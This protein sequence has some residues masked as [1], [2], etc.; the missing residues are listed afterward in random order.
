MSLVLSLWSGAGAVR[1]LVDGL[2]VAY[3]EKE[4]RTF[5]HVTVLTL[6]LTVGAILFALLAVAA[7]VVA[8]ALMT[9]LRLDA[10]AGWIAALRW[11]ALVVVLAL[12]LSLVYRYGP[13]RAQPRWRWITPGGILAAVL[14]LAA[15]L[16]FS[17]YVANFANFNKTYG[18]LGAVVGFMTWLWYSTIIVLFGA[19]LNAEIEHQTGVDTT[20]GQSRPLGARGAAMADTV[21]AAR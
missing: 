8:P 7:V 5:I 11:P 6:G 3:E 17:W 14:W 4:T 13:S 19:E 18:S 1:A 21:G 10:G 2:N 12:G 15:S 20:A 9:F 16:A